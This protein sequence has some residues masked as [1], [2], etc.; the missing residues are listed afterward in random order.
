MDKEIQRRLNYRTSGKINYTAD[1]IPNLAPKEALAEFMKGDETPY[2]KL[3]RIDYPIKANGFTYTESFFQSF[4]KNLKDAPFPGAKDGHEMQWGKRGNT[5]F[6][7]VGGLLE[8]KG[9]GKGS[10][11]L[12]NYIPP[13]GALSSNETFIKE[14]K[15]GMV[16]FSLV[17][18]VKEERIETKDGYEVN[19]V[20]SL[21][22]E[23]NDAVD[24]GTGAMQQVTN[25]A[26]GGDEKDNTQ[27]GKKTMKQELME[28]LANF[29]SEKVTLQEIAKVM[30]AEDQLV[31]DEHVQ[32]LAVVNSLK[33]L[34]VTDPVKVITE[35]RETVAKNAKAVKS[36]ALDK[37]FGSDSDDN[38]NPLRQYAEEKLS[39]ATYDDLMA[40]IEDVKKSP[41]AQKLAGDMT[42]VVK[43]VGAKEPK[44]QSADPAPKKSRVDKL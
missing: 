32:A 34:E 11:Y 19:I 1:E 15:A 10:V 17:S 18:Y 25:A 43:N 3:Q 22:G 41:I 8:S 38:P 35:L 14:N 29:K 36:A 40:G 37:A 33:K 20:E 4:L 44:G 9:D 13:M 24:R 7:L 2:F 6:I 21:Y 12:K 42:D 27:R 31:T 5:D 16:H 39:N 30:N 26:V 23:R 28:M